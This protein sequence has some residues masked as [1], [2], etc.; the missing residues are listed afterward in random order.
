MD[1]LTKISK[2]YETDKSNDHKYTIIYNKYFSEK[3]YE[4]I[5]LFEI[6]I[7]FPRDENRGGGSLQMWSEYF[8]NGTIYGLDI[9]KKKLNFDEK[10]KIFK[11]SQENFLDLKEVINSAGNFDIIIDDGSHFNKHQIKSFKYLFPYLNNGGYYIIEDIQTSYML[12]YGGDGFYLNN[13]RT[14]INYF[15]TLID[16][17]NYREIENPFFNFER[18]IHAN[19]ITEIHFYH[20]LIIIKKDIND[21]KSNLL[22]NYQFDIKGKSFLKIRKLIKQIKYSLHLIR[23]LL[24]KF[25][26]LLKF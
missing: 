17:I 12:K 26:D 6:G 5:K 16:K 13:K 22:K 4:N 20:N 25:F 14:A 1:D 9:E 11:G 21:E 3:R 8:P 7:G 2:K 23:S 10:I 24:N 19:L 15:K 18:D